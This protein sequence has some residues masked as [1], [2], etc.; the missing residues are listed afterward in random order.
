MAKPLP[1]LVLSRGF[2]AFVA[3][4]MAVSQARNLA[5]A[6]RLIVVLSLALATMPGWWPDGFLLF[7]KLARR[8]LVR[9]P[10]RYTLLASLGLALLAGRGL[11]HSIGPRRFWSGLAL[12]VMSGAAACALAINWM[13]RA[14]FRTFLGNETLTLRFVAAGLGWGLG[15]VAIIA[16]R[17]NRLGLG[18]HFD[19]RPRADGT[20]LRWANR[21]GPAQPSGS[22]RVP[23]YAGLLRCHHEA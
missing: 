16:W 1:T 23:C 21:V 12:A 19:H 17:S 3:G 6:W 14:D 11:D 18:A 20:L 5:Q 8:G 9:R 10:A 22:T 4:A 7:L 15:L 2:M 13:G